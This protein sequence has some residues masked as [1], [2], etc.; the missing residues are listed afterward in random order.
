MIFIGTCLTVDNTPR[1]VLL[2]SRTFAPFDHSIVY[3]NY[4]PC[5]RS[6]FS[7][8]PFDISSWTSSM[9]ASY[10]AYPV[11]CQRHTLKLQLLRPER[12][13]ND[14]VSVRFLAKGTASFLSHWRQYG[15][16]ILLCISHAGAQFLT[17]AP[18]FLRSHSSNR[19]LVAST[20]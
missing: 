14:M 5:S 12:R 20:N 11:Q 4:Q 13:Q 1:R 19:R 2:C 10:Y 6:A 18:F 8:G 7:S 9:R 16:L 17:R 3:F 15:F